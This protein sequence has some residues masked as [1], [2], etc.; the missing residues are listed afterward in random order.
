[1]K[2]AVDC[3]RFSWMFFIVLLLL[4]GSGC[5]SNVKRI[6]PDELARIRRVAVVPL[7][8]DDLY[9][10]HVGTT[11]FTNWTKYVSIPSWQIDAFA[12]GVVEDALRGRGGF[13]I[14]ELP[15]D[16]LTLKRLYSSTER[17]DRSPFK[18]EDFRETLATLSRL[19]GIDTFVFLER[20]RLDDPNTDIHRDGY[21]MLGKSFFGILGFANLSVVGFIRVVDARSLEMVGGGLIY[22]FRDLPRSSWNDDPNALPEEERTKLGEEIKTVYRERI[23]VRMK[24]MGLSAN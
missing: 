11:I 1:M 3:K 20:G 8:G 22:D 13:E 24:E 21:C 19:H 14:V 7:L 10:V 17:A 16:T 15:P 5:G 12:K 2:I 9:Q 6:A 4:I 18:V 23:L